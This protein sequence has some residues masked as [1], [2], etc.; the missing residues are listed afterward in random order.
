MDRAG[1]PVYPGATVKG[2][3]TSPSSPDETHFNALYSSPDSVAKIVKF[4]HDSL[5]FDPEQR[6]GVTQLVGPTSKGANVMVFV[7]PDGAATKI[8]VRGIIYK[9]PK[10]KS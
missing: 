7:E 2:Q 4:Y 5:K 1:V 9:N 6:Q 10:P 8:T 3:A